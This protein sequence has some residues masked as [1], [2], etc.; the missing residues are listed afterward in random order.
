M[1][2]WVV[3]LRTLVFGLWLLITVVPYALFL[4]LASIFLKGTALYRL[5]LGWIESEMLRLDPQAYV[6]EPP[7]LVV[8]EQP[9]GEGA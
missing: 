5:A 4:M 1:T 6:N 9:G 7:A 8:S 3:G 2:W